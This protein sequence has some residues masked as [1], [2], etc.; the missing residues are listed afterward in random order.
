MISARDGES[1]R[2]YIKDNI[3]IPVF[4]Y[5]LKRSLHVCVA[6]SVFIRSNFKTDLL[7]FPVHITPSSGLS[8]WSTILSQQLQLHP[9]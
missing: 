7:Y 4:I 9:E 1:T 2:L 3:D 5:F 8:Q 6:T